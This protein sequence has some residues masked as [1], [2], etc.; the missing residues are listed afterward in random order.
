MTWLWIP[1]T[2]AAAVSQNLRTAL[3]RHLKGRL[4]TN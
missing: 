4:S 1:I 3:Q 2:L